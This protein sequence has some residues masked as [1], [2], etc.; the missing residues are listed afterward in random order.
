MGDINGDENGVQAGVELA[1]V[2]FNVVEEFQRLSLKREIREK[3]EILGLKKMKGLERAC[4]SIN[5]EEKTPGKLQ[6]VIGDN[7]TGEEKKV[8]RR[9]LVVKKKNFKETRLTDV[10]IEVPA[11]PNLL[12]SSGQPLITTSSQ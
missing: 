5:E 2:P 6:N 8:S 3:V 12:G 11:E 1:V 9:R 4:L 7:D 10:K